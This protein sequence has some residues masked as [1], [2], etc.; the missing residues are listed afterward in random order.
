MRHSEIGAYGGIAARI[1][2]EALSASTALTG[3]TLV[4]GLGITG[5]FLSRSG[6]PLFL[7]AFLALAV[8]LVLVR[9]ALNGYGG[10][11]RGTVFS[12]SGGSWMDVGRVSLRY[13]ALNALWA[14]PLYALGAR[15]EA[16]GESMGGILMGA[17]DRRTVTL[18]VLAQA[19]VLLSP[20]IF[21]AASVGADRFTDVFRPDHW[22][23]T[24]GGRVSDLFL[25]YVVYLG[26]IGMTVV[27]GLPI[28]IAVGINNLDAAK[29][30]GFVALMLGGGLAVTLLGRLCGFYAHGHPGDLWPATVAAAPPPGVLPGTFPA[31]VSVSRSGS[32]DSSGMIRR[33]SGMTANP[34]SSGALRAP[35]I[36]ATGKVILM[37]A[38]ARVES[39]HRR[40]ERDR[41]GA[42]AELEALRAD[43]APNP[44]VL[45]ALCVLQHRAGRHEDSLR[46]GKE[47]MTLCLQRGAHKQAAELFALH[48]DQYARFEL[49]RD[50]ALLLADHLRHSRDF[51]AA[52]AAYGHVLEIDAQ[53]LRAMKGLLQVAQERLREHAYE[54][55]R[56][57]HQYLLRRCGDSPL[58]THMREGLAEAERRLAQAS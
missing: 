49:N 5:V 25:V 52:E 10:E 24:F 16:F 45:H 20:P 4:S 35:G 18:V 13:L 47:A 58:A 54:D 43:F 23:S 31:P 9:F 37:D 12:S 22:R 48:H 57:I 30:L 11:W 17:G 34:S 39:A 19:A 29:F 14:L 28:L 32:G 38:K 44:L 36:T 7:Q 21:L 50:M 26:T 15:P 55:S 40:F 53:D 27:L 56:R 1:V 6:N 51:P 46:T 8:T 41:D 3:F 2:R 42:I 33:P